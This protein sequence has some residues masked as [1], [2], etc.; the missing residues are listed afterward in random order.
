[1]SK[2]GARV[3]SCGLDATVRYEDGSHFR[4]QMPVV[5]CM[6]VNESKDRIALGGPDGGISIHFVDGRLEHHW[7]GHCEGTVYAVKFMG[8]IL[9]TASALSDIRGWKIVKSKHKL[10]CSKN[11]IHDKRNAIK[12]LASQPLNYKQLVKKRLRVAFS[13]LHL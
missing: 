8:Q 4:S 1:M 13:N 3:V 7:E 11:N 10:A 9:F 5:R 12:Y 2:I 6:A